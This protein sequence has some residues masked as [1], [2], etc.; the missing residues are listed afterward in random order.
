MNV[1]YSYRGQ[2][3][4]RPVILQ[5]RNYE[6]GYASQ[7]ATRAW[8]KKNGVLLNQK[9]KTITFGPGN[10]SLETSLETEKD[11]RIQFL[12]G[13][14]LEFKLGAR[15]K[16]NGPVQALGREGLPVQLMITSDPSRGLMGSWGG[17]LVVGANRESILRYTRVTGA[18]THSFS[19]RQDSHG[20]TGC[21]TFY[22]SSVRIEH[23]TFVGLQCEDALNI[24]SSDFSIEHVE[25]TNSSADAFDSDFSDGVVKNSVFRDIANDGIDISG[26]Q[27]QISSSWFSGIQDKSISVGESS[28]LEAT[29]LNIKGGG[30]GVVS[31]DKSIVDIYNSTF[32]NVNNALMA[33]IKKEEWGPAEIHCD[34]CL[35]DNV[36]SVAVEQ[37]ASRITIDGQEVSPTPFSRKQLQI[38]GYVQ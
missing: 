8:F 37:Y 25:F 30:A 1:S 26:S 7:K 33:Y 23:S 14:I 2:K 18:A 13:T 38:A 35:F 19:E 24:I 17:L 32:K 12:P 9:T 31:K 28:Y 29:R 11:W 6:S 4:T 5:F 36:E 15:L 10:Y 22:K 27:I 16:V 3:Y 34:N 21:I 20:L